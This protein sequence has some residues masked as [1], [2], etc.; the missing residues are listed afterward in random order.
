MHD[1]RIYLSSY[2]HDMAVKVI[3]EDNMIQD[4]EHIRKIEFQIKKQKS[5]DW[6]REKNSISGNNLPT[7]SILEIRI[8]ICDFT[9]ILT[10]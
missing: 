1:I 4:L 2:P 7:Y 5:V 9:S 3:L 8:E 10:G 6:K